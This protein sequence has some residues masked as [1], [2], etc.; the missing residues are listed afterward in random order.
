MPWIII[1]L[2]E[3]FSHG[4]FMCLNFLSSGH[5][6]CPELASGNSL[7][8]PVPA[9]PELVSGNLFRE[10]LAIYNHPCVWRTRHA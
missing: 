6:A 8:E 10:N 5:T 2:C 1:P 7:R 9:C 3:N 4:H